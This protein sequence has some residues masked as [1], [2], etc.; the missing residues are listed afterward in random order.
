MGLQAVGW[1]NCILGMIA[2]LAGIGA[3]VTW[4]WSPGITGTPNADYRLDSEALWIPLLAI[5]GFTAWAALHVAFGV[6]TLVGSARARALRCYGWTLGLAVLLA[7]PI[8]AS[9]IVGLPVAIWIFAVWLRTPTRQAFTEQARRDREEIRNAAADLAQA[10]ALP[11]KPT[12]PTEL[13][14]GAKRKLRGPAINLLIFSSINLATAVMC[15][16]SIFADYRTPASNILILLAAGMMA[17][18][19]TAILFG[20]IQMLR[21]RWYSMAMFAG[22]VALLPCGPAWPLTLI[23]GILALVTLNRNEVRQAFAITD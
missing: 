15:V 11:P 8:H 5:A 16:V 12:D 10:S 19:G 18:C 23:F 17:L 20:A 4:F 14:A 7:L 2:V 6:G 13:R 1:L 9:W 21:L 3:L 22:I